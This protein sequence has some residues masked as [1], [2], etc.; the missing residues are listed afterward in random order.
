M[1]LSPSLLVYSFILQ[2]KYVLSCIYLLILLGTGNLK[3]FRIINSCQ[4]FSGLNFFKVR[5]KSN[6]KAYMNTY[7]S[8]YSCIYEH[9]YIMP[10]VNKAQK[11]SKAL[12]ED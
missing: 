12:L 1:Y 11:K 6:F 7:I 10:D 9:A 2:M 4:M 5:E 3:S 8:I